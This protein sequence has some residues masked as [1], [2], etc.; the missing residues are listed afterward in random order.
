MRDRLAPT[1]QYAHIC[2]LLAIGCTCKYV[3]V[4]L[5][6]LPDES[7]HD[8]LNSLVHAQRVQ[9]AGSGKKSQKVVGAVFVFLVVFLVRNLNKRNRHQLSYRQ[10][11][12]S[13]KVGENVFQAH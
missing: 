4:Q 13:S 11:W 3:K 5:S 9:K 7:C 2:R 12:Y 10:F 8:H 6:S 1:V